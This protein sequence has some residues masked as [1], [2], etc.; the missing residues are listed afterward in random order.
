MAQDAQSA[1]LQ[2]SA[3]GKADEATVG[4][5]SPFLER[6]ISGAGGEVLDRA[7][8]ELQA[9]RLSVAALSDQDRLELV[10]ACLHGTMLT[11]S[12]WVRACCE[13]K[14]IPSS[15]SA[16]AE[17][18]TAGPLTVI[19]YL[20]LLAQTLNA[21]QSSPLPRLPGRL[22]RSRD[23]RLW[24]PVFPTRGL[25]YDRVLLPGL[26][27]FARMASDV[28]KDNLSEHIACELRQGAGQPGRIA[29]VLGAGN[30]SSIPATDFLMKLFAESRLVLLKLSP[31]NDYLG[32]I[33][34]QAFAPILRAG[35]LRIIY[36]GAD[37]GERAA[38]DARV[39][40]VHLTGSATTHE[41]LV[42]GS[43]ASER[44]NRRR[45][46][47]PRLAKPITSELGNVSPWIVV[48]GNYSDRQLRFQAENLAASVVN[49]AGFNCVAT[50]VLITWRHWPQRERFLRLVEA[51]LRERFRPERRTIQDRRNGFARPSAISRAASAIWAFSRGHCFATSTP[52]ARR[53]F[54]SKRRSCPF[55]R[56][57]R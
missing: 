42:W 40:E 14:R 46:G 9:S 28:T 16:V 48:P 2:P 30:V 43:D 6:S 10:E 13:A 29:L 54:C 8:R 51:V 12:E 36:G 47:R 11:A 4:S 26:H 33:F 37:L 23:G 18:I 31:V 32:P 21:L 5:G 22:R 27:V 35:Y 19:R 17:E 55:W 50:R 34:E 7:L 41:R 53:S 20:R 49:N 56:K 52:T 57:S 25:F 38:F 15:S 24:V 45:D 44:Q 39:D 1:A 3:F